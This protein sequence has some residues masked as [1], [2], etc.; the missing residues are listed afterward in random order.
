MPFPNM[1]ASL[2]GVRVDRYHE[3]A[4][5]A[6]GSAPDP[7]NGYRTQKLGDGLYIITDGAGGVPAGLTRTQLVRRG[8]G[9]TASM[10]RV[11]RGNSLRQSPSP[12][13]TTGEACSELSGDQPEKGTYMSL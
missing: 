13:P 3:V 11:P 1:L 12:Y 2:I 9:G 8:S 6:K 5:S 10:P 4:E 7:A